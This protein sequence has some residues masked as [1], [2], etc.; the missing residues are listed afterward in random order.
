MESV[1]ANV[2]N[3]KKMGNEDES[4]VK[5]QGRSTNVAKI[6]EPNIFWYLFWK[7]IWMKDIEASKNPL[8]EI[9]VISFFIAKRDRRGNL[10]IILF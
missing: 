7:S 2:E 1:L 10:E 6:I 4:D 3:C 5:D 9:N 8:C